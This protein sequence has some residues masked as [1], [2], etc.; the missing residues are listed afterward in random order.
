MG[1]ELADLLFEARLLFSRSTGA[2]CSDTCIHLR[3]CQKA[4][5]GFRLL[6][7]WASLR[8]GDTAFR[9]RPL[10]PRPGA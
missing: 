2:A 7:H 4:F 10:R 8:W 6:R 3:C 1:K 5:S 9:F